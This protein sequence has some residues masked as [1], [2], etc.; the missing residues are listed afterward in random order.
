MDDSA[1]ML[2]AVKG[3]RADDGKESRCVA[4]SASQRSDSSAQEDSERYWV[5]PWKLRCRP[6]PLPKFPE[7]VAAAK[8]IQRTSL[9]SDPLQSR[10]HPAIGPLL[11]SFTRGHGGL[12]ELV[13]LLGRAG[14][15]ASVSQATGIAW[16]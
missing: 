13:G 6:L 8:W 7:R 10:K 9:W 4:C 12:A 1:R 5:S 3:E 15:L 11:P 16:W 14:P 2:P